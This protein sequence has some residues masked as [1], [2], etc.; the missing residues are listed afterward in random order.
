M[1]PI[2]RLASKLPRS[3]FVGLVLV[4]ALILIFMLNPPHSVCDSQFAIFKADQTPFL[5]LDPKK[6][7]MKTSGYQASYDKCSASNNLGA[8][9]D[10]FGATRQLMSD[11]ASGNPRCH[12]EFFNK[13]EVKKALTDTMS[14]MIRLAWGNQPPASIYEKNGWLNSNHMY[15]YCELKANFLNHYGKPAYETWREKQMQAL[16]NPK[17]IDRR[18]VWNRSLVSIDCKPFS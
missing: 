9:A 5:Y 16:P 18:E 14:L 12:T 6:P 15:L 13:A 17:N 3:I 1:D 11:L 10:L 2:E 8:C 4:V 7:Y